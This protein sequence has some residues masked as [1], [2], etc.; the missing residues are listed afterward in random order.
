MN[1]IITA[2]ELDFTSNLIEQPIP[3]L[4]ESRLCSSEGAIY[5]RLLSCRLQD[6]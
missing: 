1:F 5:L 6:I 3:Q 4:S 2:S